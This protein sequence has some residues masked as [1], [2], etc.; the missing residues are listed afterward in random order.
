MNQ[1]KFTFLSFLRSD[2]FTAVNND[3]IRILGALEAMTFSKI[4]SYAFYSNSKGFMDEDGWFRLSKSQLQEEL[5][6]GRKPLDSVINKLILEQLIEYK[7]KGNPAVGHFRLTDVIEIRITAI[8]E[9]LNQLESSVSQMDILECPNWAIKSDPNGHTRVSQMD[10][11]IYKKIIKNNKESVEKISHTEI[12]KQTADSAM[13]DYE[14]LV[15]AYNSE[16]LN[17]LILEN[18][19]FYGSFKPIKLIQYLRQPKQKTKSKDEEIKKEPKG[20]TTYVDFF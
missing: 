12:L 6:T 3:L 1:N 14:E 16:S 15:S 10:K 19:E 13:I 18:I 8:F 7:S 20:K 17:L 11:H 2:N 4:L 5:A 9:R